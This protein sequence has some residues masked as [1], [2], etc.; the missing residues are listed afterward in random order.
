M[1]NALIYLTERQRNI[2]MNF[3][4]KNIAL[5]LSI[6]IAYSI[7][8]YTGEYWPD[9]VH[10]LFGIEPDW[11]ATKYKFP[12]II[13]AFMIFPGIRWLKKTIELK[14]SR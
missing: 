14:L 8:H 3:I 4:N 6:A 7:V 2:K 5:I 9:I 11:S 1:K 12:V 13:I 10:S